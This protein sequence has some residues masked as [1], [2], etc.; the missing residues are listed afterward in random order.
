[1]KDFII[2]NLKSAKIKFEAPKDIIINTEKDNNS[3]I[4]TEENNNNNS[5]IDTDENNNNSFIDTEEDNN[6]YY[7][8]DTEEDNNS[9]TDTKEDNNNSFTDTKEDNIKQTTGEISLEQKKN[10]NLSNDI[11]NLL[12]CLNNSR[13]KYEYWIKIGIIIYNETNN[14]NIW[15]VWS[16]KSEHY[17]K[18]EL[19]TKWATFNNSCNNKLTIAT[20]HKYAQEDNIKKYS[21]YFK[22]SNFFNEDISTTSTALYFKKL[23]N[24][25][26]IYKNDKLYN[27]NGVYWKIDDNKLSILNNFIVFFIH[28][29]ELLRNEEDRI[30]NNKLSD[31]ELKIK[32]KYLEIQK[33]KIFELRNND[34]RCKYINEI[35]CKITNDD[36]KFDE[37]PYLFAFNNKIFDLK[38]GKFIEPKA[39]QF[40]SITTGYNFIE[41]DETNNINKLH[42]LLDSI[43]P[44]P[45]LKKLYLTILSTGLDGIPLEKFILANGRGGNGK[46]LLNEFVQHMLGNYAYVLP[47][48]IL[49]G[50]LKTGSN[51]EI[52]NMNNKRLV[53]AREPDKNLMFNCATI[54]EIT[55]GTELNARLNHSNDTKVLL[56]LLFLLEC[57]DKPKLN[58]VNDA[59]AWRILDF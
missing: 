48:N 9:L 56:K 18:Q 58:E 34:K 51:P 42:Q 1:M 12:S 37:N 32:L 45:E 3:F 36:I 11:I 17:N 50:P 22:V 6:N 47:V 52:A 35:I 31:D 4:D 55:G 8:I 59:L 25:Q 29:L 40:I 39:D 14:I 49:L 43:F 15:K 33:K 10:N 7:F 21:S 41:Q 26:F 23:Y 38:E 46:G 2:T 5:F 54:K 24:D 30:L 13:F 53:I 20:L 27:F 16:K 19:K 44:Q 57:N 28:L